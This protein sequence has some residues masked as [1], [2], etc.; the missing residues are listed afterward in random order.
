MEGSN[1]GGFEKN[2]M[3]GDQWNVPSLMVLRRIQYLVVNEMFQA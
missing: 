2:A 3:F 1:L